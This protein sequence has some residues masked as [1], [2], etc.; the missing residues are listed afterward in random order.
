MV[1]SKSL[2]FIENEFQ[3]A[4]YLSKKNKFVNIIP[5]TFSF[6]AERELS[7]GKVKFKTEEEY[8]SSKLYEKIHE[9]SLKETW[10]ICKN[11]NLKYRSVELLPLFYYHIYIIL[12]SCKKNLRLFEE[13][14]KKEKPKKIIFFEGG[15]KTQNETEFASKIIKKIFKGELEKITYSSKNTKKINLKYQI[16]KIV[17]SAQKIITKLRLNFAKNKR[18]IFI[19]GGKTYFDSVTRLLVKDKRNKVFPFGNFSRK[20]FFVILNYMRSHGFYDQKSPLKNGLP[21]KINV[22]Y[23]EISQKNFFKEFDI[24]KE[25][26]EIVKSRLANMIKKNVLYTA[27][28]LEELYSVMKKKKIDMILLSGEGSPFSRGIVQLLKQF[29]IPTIHFQHGL[30]IN[31]MPNFVNS[32]YVFSIGE[33]PK[34]QFLKYASKNSKIE[35]I[36]CPRYDKFEKRDYGNKKIILYAMEIANGND[37]VPDTHLTKKRQK[38]ILEQ[39]FKVMK[40]FPEY[41]LI[42]KTRPGWEMAKLPELVA[43]KLSFSN[44][45]VIEKADNIKLLNESEIVII[46]STTMGIEA[47]LLDRPVISFSYKD[48]DKFNPYTKIDAVKVVY[49]STQL[50]ELIEKLISKKHK[51]LKK[52]NFKQWLF[53]DKGASERAVK[54]IHK[55]LKKSTKNF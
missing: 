48:L 49:S 39:I 29:N 11:I 4:E 43:R 17:N 26:D 8:E 53:Y 15:D 51:N 19:C 16:L 9:S 46:N 31:E 14:I 33:F 5:I 37:I 40:D 27:E 54:L 36:G 52:G 23:E 55:I 34:K 38:E 32:D 42:I 18:K 35:V 20:S 1:K 44:F 22:I 10:K 12:T 21:Q 30:F 2:I 45:E 24:A 6:G 7:G 41:K 13:I 50:K 28:F 47:L 3:A 25:I